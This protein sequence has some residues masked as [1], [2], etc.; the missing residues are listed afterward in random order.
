MLNLNFF[1]FGT[2][3]HVRIQKPILFKIELVVPTQNLS[4]FIFIQF[5]KYHQIHKTTHMVYKKINKGE[6]EKETETG[7]SPE[8]WPGQLLPF[9][10]MFEL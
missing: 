9:A 5:F 7:L 10:P 2:Q 4:L 1:I 8:R 3:L 6:M